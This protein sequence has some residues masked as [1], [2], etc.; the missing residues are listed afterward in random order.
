MLNYHVPLVYIATGD[1]CTLYNRCERRETV[2]PSMGM[3]D[4]LNIL[5][6]RLPIWDTSMRL[7][8]Y[9]WVVGCMHQHA[10]EENVSRETRLHP[11]PTYEP[12]ALQ[13]LLF[14]RGHFF[15]ALVQVVRRRLYDSE[16]RGL[17]AFVQCRE[18]VPERKSN[19]GELHADSVCCCGL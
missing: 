18:E 7:S 10:I 12:Q 1:F 4:S 8:A 15:V 9:S 17:V 6:A 2:N 13:L 14:K 11:L 19:G 3:E 16:I 5:L